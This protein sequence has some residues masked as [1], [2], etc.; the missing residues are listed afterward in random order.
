[1]EPHERISAKLSK[2]RPSLTLAL[3]R[4]AN[5]RRAQNLP[6]YDF[7]LGETKGKLEP[8]IREAGERAF[9][10]EHTMYTDPAGLP[11][12]RAAVLKWMNCE[13]HYGPENVI[14]SAGAKQ[15]LFNIFLAI[16]NPADCILFDAAPWVSYQPLATAAYAFPV[17]VLPLKNPDTLKVSGDDLRRNLRMR[18]HVKMFLLNS[19]V[20]PTAQLYSAGELEEL[21]SVCVEHRVFFVLDRL[22]WRIVFDGG[23]YPEP[24]IDA[25][26]RPWLI[27]VDGMS[28]NFRRTGGMRIGWCVAPDDVAAA[29]VNLQSHYTAGPATPTQRAALAAITTP[30]RNDMVVEL[31]GKRDLLYRESQDMPFIK[32]W[33]T[34]ASFYSFWDVRGCFGRRTPQGKVL[35]TSDDVAEYLLTSAGLITA[36]GSGFMQDGYLRLSFATPDAHITEGMRATRKALSAMS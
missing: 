22:Y 20:N 35:Q 8:E 24:R 23:T 15:S 32:V 1:M 12:L 34:P 31:Q 11:E 18:P 3:K 21:L 5:E 10:E 26:T 4:L 33:R 6:V 36:S 7:G 13:K 17:Q 2:F 30:Y 29:M 27:Q 16:C 25:Q 28:K 19:P 14:I 9:R